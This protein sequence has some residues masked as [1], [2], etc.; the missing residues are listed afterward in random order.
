M[1]NIS[2]SYATIWNVEDRGNYV[3]A[4]IS[5]SRK[6]NRDNSY[7]NSNWFARFVGNCKDA[8]K[9]LKERDRIV[10]TNGTVENVYD[11]NSGKS[12]VNVVI[13]D[14]DMADGSLPG[15]TPYE[16]SNDELPF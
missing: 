11:K 9:N 7:I 12:Y 10:I 13:F 3:Q 6:D 4:R 5:T 2:K 8:A 16:G 14:F 1:L 15:F